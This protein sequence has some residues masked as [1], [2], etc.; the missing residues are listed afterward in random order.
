MSQGHDG[1][2]NEEIA[3]HNIERRGKNKITRRFMA[4]FGVFAGFNTSP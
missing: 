4:E 2:E 1:P 3:I